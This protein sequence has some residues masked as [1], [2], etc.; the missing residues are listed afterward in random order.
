[1][2]WGSLAG[3]AVLLTIAVLLLRVLWYWLVALL[4]L[5]P[6]TITG[7]AIGHF[8]GVQL[9]SVGAG[10]IVAVF[11]SGCLV[12]IVRHWL[13]RASEGASKW[14]DAAQQERSRKS[15]VR[16]SDQ[17]EDFGGASSQND[18]PVVYVSS[19]TSTPAV[20]SSAI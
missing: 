6:P 15:A 10:I 4:M 2:D 12:E 3:F 19:R 5:G 7:L 17:L 9:N 16:A 11:V 14:R 20:K 13:R 8:V 1:M 18:Y